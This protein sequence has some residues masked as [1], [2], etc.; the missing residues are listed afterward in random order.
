MKKVSLKKQAEYLAKQDARLGAV[1]RRVG[2]LK[3]RQRQGHEYFQALVEEIISQ[4]LSGRVADVIT[5]RFVALF[6]RAPAFPEPHEILTAS[7]GLLRSSGM[8]FSKAAYIKNIARAVHEGDLV[9]RELNVRTDEEVITQLVGIKGIGRWTAEMFL[10]FSLGRED[11]FSAGD[12][13]LKNAMIRLYGLRTEPDAARMKKIASR[14]QPYRTLACR[15]L[16][17]SLDNRLVL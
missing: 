13:G 11:V 10:M 9:L 6:G 2:A 8:S 4:Q 7:D 16:W 12:L 17:A 14:W 5:E 15:Y 1:I 3:R